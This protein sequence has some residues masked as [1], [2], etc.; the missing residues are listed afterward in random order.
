MPALIFCYRLEGEEEFFE[1]LF[2]YSWRVNI[3]ELRNVIERSIVLL[4]D[5]EKL[6]LFDLPE[7]IVKAYNYKSL[8]SQVKLIKDTKNDSS[9][10]M[11]L[12]EEIEIEILLREENGN[13]SRVADRLNISRTTL[14][15]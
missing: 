10:L 13:L 2:H 3:R 1:A 6:S 12:S 11:K 8:K 7:R 15:K 4:R 14:V 9:S 5:K